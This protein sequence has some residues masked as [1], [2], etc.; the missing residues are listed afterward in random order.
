M[1]IEKKILS[2]FIVA[3]VFLSMISLAAAEEDS[4][5]N[6]NTASVE[7]LMQLKG[8]GKSYAERIVEYREKNGP[9]K[10]IE[11]IMKIKGIGSKTFE[12]IQAKLKV[13][14]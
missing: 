7:D 1:Q 12:N 10:N 13:N 8:I 4:K 9:F 6:L 11:D 5:I 2:L 14:E 3:L